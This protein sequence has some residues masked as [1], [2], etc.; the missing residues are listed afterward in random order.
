MCKKFVR[1]LPNC[2]IPV[3]P[4]K[5]E[6]LKRFLGKLSNYRRVMQ[7]YWLSFDGVDN[8]LSNAIVGCRAE[9]I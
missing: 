6:I 5:F 7:P 2:E 1:V 4:V 9:V 3:K 8:A